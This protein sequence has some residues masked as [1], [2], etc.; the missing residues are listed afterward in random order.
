MDV[1]ANE[2]RYGVLYTDNL[3]TYSK[4]LVKQP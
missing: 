3:K 1:E 4:T 2:F